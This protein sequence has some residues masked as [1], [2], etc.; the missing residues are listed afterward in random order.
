MY[1]GKI[2]AFLITRE[3]EVCHKRDLLTNLT[4]LYAGNP[5]GEYIHPKCRINT[6][7][8]RR[9]QESNQ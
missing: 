2:L 1:I 5:S 9:K 6:C 8:D 7:Y 4:R 3:C